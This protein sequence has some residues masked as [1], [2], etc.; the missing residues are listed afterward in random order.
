MHTSLGFS[1]YEY[2]IILVSS[3]T[4]PAPLISGLFLRKSPNYMIC[5]TM[6]C[7]RFNC[8]FYIDNHITHKY[9]LFLS[10]TWAFYL[11]FLSYYTVSSRLAWKRGGD[12]FVLFLTLI[13]MILV[14]HT[15]KNDAY[16]KFNRYPI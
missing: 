7:H 2:M 13:G 9:S 11:F 3:L 1:Y 8:V 10:N 12:T 14:F 15:K 5:H 16:Y 4:L 6:I